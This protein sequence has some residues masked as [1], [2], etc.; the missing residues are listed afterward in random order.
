MESDDKGISKRIINLGK[1]IYAIEG[2]LPV[3][4]RESAPFAE[5]IAWMDRNGMPTN[6][7]RTQSKMTVIRLWPPSDFDA[8]E[9]E[10]YLRGIK[11]DVSGKLK[12][13]RSRG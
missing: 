1:H 4:Q 8:F 13:K 5:W 3:V 6:W 9:R 2:K 11:D 7:I 10:Q 12:T